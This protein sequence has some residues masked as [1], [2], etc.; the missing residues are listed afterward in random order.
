MCVDA[1]R[2]IGY[3]HLKRCIVIANFFRERGG[4]VCIGTP[5]CNSVRNQFNYHIA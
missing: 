2:E 4:I 3:G 5:D 1:Y